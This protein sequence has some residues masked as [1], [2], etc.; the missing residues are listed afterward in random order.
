MCIFSLKFLILIKKTKRKIR[1]KILKILLTQKC[2]KKK[3]PFFFCKEREKYLKK[4]RNLR[5]F[6]FTRCLDS[7][8]TK[9]PSLHWRRVANSTIIQ[10]SFWWKKKLIL[11]WSHR[12][13]RLRTLRKIG[14]KLIFSFWIFLD[15]NRLFALHFNIR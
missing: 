4:N 15:Q 6:F 14:F 10:I 12:F 9:I 11:K 7:V 2:N 3:F 8:L 13:F 5:Q 1:N